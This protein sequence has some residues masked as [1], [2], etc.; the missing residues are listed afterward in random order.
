[1]AE[2]ETKYG[3]AE[4]AAE[5]AE[6]QWSALNLYLSGWVDWQLA[7]GRGVKLRSELSV[8][9]E[10]HPKMPIVKCVGGVPG[11]LAT[12]PSVDSFTIKASWIISSATSWQ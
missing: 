5:D 9:V 6:C 4:V 7:L 8:V 3:Q 10:E 11:V 1:M 2:L 12:L